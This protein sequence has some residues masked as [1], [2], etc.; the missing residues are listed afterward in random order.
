MDAL[1]SKLTKANEAYRNGATLLMTDDEY[2]AGL[3]KLKKVQPDHP[4]LKQVRAAPAPS[5]K[6]I[7][8]PFYLG[9]LDKAKTA[10]ELGK[11][12]KKHSGPFL[13]SET[14]RSSFDKAT[15]FVCSEDT[16]SHSLSNAAVDCIT[17]AAVFL[18][19]CDL[20]QHKVIPASAAA[21]P[22]TGGC[23]AR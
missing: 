5:E 23:S 2:D 12:S 3:E 17:P 4:L 19:N 1:I 7:R 15:S 18:Q 10:E 16:H 9:S 20:R 21:M 8:M 13:I 14:R 22:R 6:V 11:W